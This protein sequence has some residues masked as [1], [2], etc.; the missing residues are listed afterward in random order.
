MVL[1]PVFYVLYRRELV[2]ALRKFSL[3]TKVTPSL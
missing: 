1:Q 3:L 2:P